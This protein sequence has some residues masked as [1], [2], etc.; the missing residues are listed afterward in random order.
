MWLINPLQ[1]TPLQLQL[2]SYP[3][4]FSASNYT[5]L[6]L[7]PSGLVAPMLVNDHPR[8]GSNGHVLPLEFRLQHEAGQEQT[9]ASE[10]FQE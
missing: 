1:V 3:R 2:I 6:N 7:R 10:R 8:D 9:C 5:H 4:I